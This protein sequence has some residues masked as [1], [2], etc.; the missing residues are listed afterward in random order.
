MEMELNVKR[1]LKIWHLVIVHIAAGSYPVQWARGS[2][3]SLYRG[4][5]EKFLELC[6]N[7]IQQVPLL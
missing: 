1:F 5:I 6:Q 4:Q 3:I 7:H 2:E